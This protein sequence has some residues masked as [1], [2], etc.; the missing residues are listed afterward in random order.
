M[1]DLAV[2]APTVQALETALG[3]KNL[4]EWVEAQ[5]TRLARVEGES[6]RVRLT[7]ELLRARGIVSAVKAL[8]N[9][10]AHDAVIDFTPPGYVIRY[11]VTTP[12]RIRFSIAHEIAH[13]YFSD[14]Q[15]RALLRLDHATDPTVESICNYLARALLLPRDRLIA[16]LRTLVGQE[17]IPPLH[18][19]PQ[20]AGEFEVSEQVVARRLVFDVFSGFFAAIC[21]TKYAEKPGWQTTWCAPLGDF[22]LPRSSGWRVP[23]DS[24]ARK[25]PH[26][27]VPKFEPGMTAVTSVDGRWAKLCR[28]STISQCRIPFARLPALP[29]VDAVVGSPAVDRGLFDVPTERCFV[30]L[31]EQNA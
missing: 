26:D 15:G 13:T 27:M 30:A 7:G 21:I 4:L 22:D 18:L 5:A 11:R 8:P 6:G 1:R 3:C 24:N 29:G 23:L 9:R 2:R 10:L 16:R 12:T 19:V 14:E 20:L 17:F 28:P 25:V 31:W